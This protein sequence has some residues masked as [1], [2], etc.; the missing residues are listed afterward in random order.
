MSWEMPAH[1]FP[2]LPGHPHKPWC[3]GNG[4]FSLLLPGLGDAAP[5]PAMLQH[6]QW[7][8]GGER[9]H[10]GT[11]MLEALHFSHLT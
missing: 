7:G 4:R 11:V 3:L 1:L 8:Q 9:V 10:L 2:F 6:S 5:T